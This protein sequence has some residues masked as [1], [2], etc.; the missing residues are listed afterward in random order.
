MGRAVARNHVGQGGQADIGR[1]AELHVVGDPDLRY[2]GGRSV[3]GDDGGQTVDDLVLVRQFGRR[4]GRD[5]RRLGL[6]LAERHH[7]RRAGLA[8]IGRD[9]VRSAGHGVGL[10]LDGWRD[11]ERLR[12]VLAE[13]HHGRRAGFAGIGRDV[14]RSAGHG[15]GL[16]LDGWRDER[17][18]LGLR[19]VPRRPDHVWSARH[20]S[21][22]VPVLAE[23]R[24]HL[25]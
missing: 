19:L 20:G 25:G 4:L 3:C 17:R 11:D 18:R 10:V 21:G 24:D 22:L 14:V 6:V 16:V 7:G 12:L 5:D 2:H 15:L 8:G 1:I 13:R 23:R 9:V